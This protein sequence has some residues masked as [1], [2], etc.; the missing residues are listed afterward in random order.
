MGS[1]C[2]SIFFLFDDYLLVESAFVFVVG[3]IKDDILS[4]LI[5]SKCL[6]ELATL[7]SVLD[8]CFIDYFN[9]SL[10]GCMPWNC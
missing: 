5:F 1:A 2:K 7:K 6:Y 8:I 3:I 4:V 9:I 10:L